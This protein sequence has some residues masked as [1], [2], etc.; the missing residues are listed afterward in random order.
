[1]SAFIVGF[2]HAEYARRGAACAAAL[3]STLKS[4]RATTDPELTLRSSA[5]ELA[6]LI[7]CG[8]FALLADGELIAGAGQLPECGALRELALQ[9]EAK[10]SGS[11]TFATDRLGEILANAPAASAEAS[12]VLAAWI[13]ASRPLLALWLRPEQVKNFSGGVPPP[14]RMEDR[15]V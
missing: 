1:M 14:D 4:L 3:E 11:E 8:A 6:R 13:E 12:G 10:R 9:I 5:D 7:D 15:E 2:G